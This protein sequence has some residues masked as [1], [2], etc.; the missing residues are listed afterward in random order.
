MQSGGRKSVTIAEIQDVSDQIP[1]GLNP[2]L[3]FLQSIDK[4]YF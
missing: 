3:D 2:R 1:Y 4:L